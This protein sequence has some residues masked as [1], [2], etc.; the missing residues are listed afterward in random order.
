MEKWVQIFSLWGYFRGKGENSGLKFKKSY[1]TSYIKRLDP[2]IPNIPA[3]HYSIIPLRFP[4]HHIHGQYIIGG[5]NKE[6]QVYFL[7]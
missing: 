3:S 1:R 4:G 7:D 5:K 2:F 6:R